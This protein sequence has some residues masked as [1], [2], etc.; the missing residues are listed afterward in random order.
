MI[1]EHETPVSVNEA[2]LLRKVDFRLLPMLGVVYFVTFLDRSV[3]K[4]GLKPID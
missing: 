1:E 2:K 3:V 4:C